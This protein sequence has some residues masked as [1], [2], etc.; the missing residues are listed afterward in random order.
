MVKYV[1]PHI[2]GPYG[3]VLKTQHLCVHARKSTRS[4]T[5]GFHEHG[6]TSARAHPFDHQPCLFAPLVV[7][8]LGRM[9]SVL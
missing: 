9:I 8:S 3:V 1:Y 4:Q 7:C 2:T 5:A 6:F